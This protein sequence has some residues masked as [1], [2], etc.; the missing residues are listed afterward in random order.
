[1][2]YLLVLGLY[3]TSVS[4]KQMHIA[5]VLW[6]RIV[7]GAHRRLTT[8]LF[9][10]SISVYENI[11]DSPIFHRYYD[12]DLLLWYSTRSCRCQLCAKPALAGFK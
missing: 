11:L 3:F 2:E 1:M 9:S 4:M 7:L 6:R 5:D 10:G 8:F 12:L